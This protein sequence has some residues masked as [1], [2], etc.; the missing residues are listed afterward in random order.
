MKSTI[1]ERD[2]I[3]FRRASIAFH[4]AAAVVAG[5]IEV[6]LLIPF[7]F[8]LARA[9]V[10]PRHGWCPAQIG[11]VEIIGATLVPIVPLLVLP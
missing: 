6:A 5:L 11:A 4:V 7:G 1:R 8:L 9:V 3:R 10:V 2:D